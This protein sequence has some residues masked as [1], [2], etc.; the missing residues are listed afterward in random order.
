MKFFTILLAIGLYN[1][2]NAIAQTD[3]IKLAADDKTIWITDQPVPKAIIQSTRAYRERLLADPY[4]PAYHFCLPEGNGS[5]GDPN[6]AFF[7]NGRYHLMYL[8]NRG[9]KGFRGGT[10][11]ARTRCTGGTTRMH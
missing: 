7:H 2:S 6:G 5:P 10:C 9:A 1:L 8:Y 4:R 3:T 11:L